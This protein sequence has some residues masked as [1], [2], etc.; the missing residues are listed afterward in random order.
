MEENKSKENDEYNKMLSQYKSKIQKGKKEKQSSTLERLQAFRS[1]LQNTNN[2]N[3]QSD[4]NNEN[5]EYDYDKDDGFGDDW[6]NHKLQSNQ[7]SR[8]EEDQSRRA[9][10]EYDVIDPRAFKRAKRNA[11]PNSDVIAKSGGGSYIRR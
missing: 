4:K 3:Q 2:E 1:S 9:E 11:N 10:D 8:L 5:E 7:T 6:M